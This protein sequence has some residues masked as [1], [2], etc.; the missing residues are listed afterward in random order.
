[1]ERKQLEED[2]AASEALRLQQLREA[3]IVAM[4]GSIEPQEEDDSSLSELESGD[5]LNINEELVTDTLICTFEKVQRNK[6]KWKLN[7]KDGVLNVN[8]K[9]YLFQRANGEGE[10]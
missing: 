10:W 6:N 3:R 5:E 8:G 2:R 1:M 9:D 7:L 4:G